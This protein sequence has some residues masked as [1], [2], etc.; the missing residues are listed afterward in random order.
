MSFL[1]HNAFHKDCSKSSLLA[2]SDESFIVWYCVVYWPIQF[3]P[4][5]YHRVCVCVC[6]CRIEDGLSTL[7]LDDWILDVCW[8]ETSSSKTS[9]SWTV[10]AV[11]AHNTVHIIK[12]SS[13]E[14]GFTRDARVV[15]D[16]RCEINCIL[17]PTE[18]GH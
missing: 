11:T 5:F 18:P 17:Y 1:Y 10:A 16:Y 12:F 13:S 8:L 7:S 14:N 9:P 6:V 3:L 4:F 2:Y 15:A